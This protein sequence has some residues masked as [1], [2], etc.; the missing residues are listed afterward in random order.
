M[1]YYL[2]GT[3]TVVKILFIREALTFVN[4]LANSEKLC[5]DADKKFIAEAKKNLEYS[6]KSSTKRVLDIWWRNVKNP[7]VC[8]RSSSTFRLLYN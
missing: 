2:R 5:E 7:D 4:W 3:Q 8:I 1:E 6:V